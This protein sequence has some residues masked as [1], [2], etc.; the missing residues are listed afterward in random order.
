MNLSTRVKVTQVLG[1]TSAG[2]S[3]VKA[4]IVD[5]ANFDGVMFVFELGQ[6]TTAGTVDA[7]VKGDAAN[8]TSAMT[9]LLGQTAHTVSATEAGYT[10]SCIIVDIFQPDPVLHRYLEANITPAL[11]TA[12]ILGVTA[13]QYSGRVHPDAQSASVIETTFLQSPAE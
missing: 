9:R 12:V 8:S 2:T 10:K 6:L 3:N 11:Q 7:F 13:I 5:M 4:D 1:Y